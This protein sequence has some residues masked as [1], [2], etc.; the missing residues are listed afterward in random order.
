VIDT[1]N[2]E[3]V[4]LGPERWREW[5]NTNPN[6][7]RTLQLN[8]SF[9]SGLVT[10]EECWASQL[11]IGPLTLSN[12][13]VHEANLSE[14]NFG[15]DYTATLGVTALERL[16]LIVDGKAGVA[17]L[18]PRPGPFRPY[19]YNRAGLGFAPNDLQDVAN[20]EAKAVVLKDGPAYQAGI[21]DGDTL[22]KIG[23]QGRTNWTENLISFAY[24]RPTGSKTELTLKRG[25]KTFTAEVVL[26][27]L[28]PP[29]ASS[30]GP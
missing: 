7:P 14:R 22:L 16:D 30:A 9:G 3:G 8:Y 13:P 2:S 5:T 6:R 20:S 17:Y 10:N 26:Q 11:P 21:R 29:A 1:G 27:D 4:S 15:T 23:D 12:V 19:S 18:R 25:E 28:F 24:D